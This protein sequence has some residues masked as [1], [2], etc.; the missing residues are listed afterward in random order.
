LVKNT[1]P[2]E[3]DARETESDSM[4]TNLLRLPPRSKSCGDRSSPIFQKT[5]PGHHRNISAILSAVQISFLLIAF[6]LSSGTAV[7]L[8]QQTAQEQPSSQ[9]VPSP[10]PSAQTT[11]PAQPLPAPIPPGPV[12]VL[13]PAHGGTDTGAR[14]AGGAV[15][16]DIVLQF[17]RTVRAELERQGYR[18]MMTRNDDSNPT[19]DDR[20]AIANSH[21]DAIFI[22][23]HISSTGTVGTARSYYY[24]FASP[25]ASPASSPALTSG[26][27]PTPPPS[28]L[29]IWDD[30]QRAYDET[31]HR[32]ADVLQAQLAQLFSGSP[33]ASTGAALRGLRSVTAPAVAVEISSVSVPNAGSLGAMTAP[34]ATSIVKTLLLF[35]PVSRAAARQ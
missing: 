14:G 28:G 5:G 11:P 12:I 22:T 34:L 27:P 13:D 21:R 3:G 30:A 20:A 23:L 24:Q 10:S 6:F 25:L 4:A 16:K 7:L 8:A 1:R 35:R 15:E 2:L 19:H 29:V 18:V 26:N 32:L 31:S 9:Q 17:A 33:S